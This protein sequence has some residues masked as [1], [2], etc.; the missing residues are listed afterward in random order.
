MSW[1]SWRWREHAAAAA[2][3]EVSPADYRSFNLVVADRRTDRQ[4]VW[5]FA[6]GRPDDTPQIV[7]VR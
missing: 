2:L 6:A 3:A 4:P 1:F 5:L 7:S